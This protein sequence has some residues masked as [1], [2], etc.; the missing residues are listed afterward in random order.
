MVWDDKPKLE[1]DLSEINA[2]TK[3]ISNQGSDM[4]RQS[5]LRGMVELETAVIELGENFNYELC[6]QQDNTSVNKLYW[7]QSKPS[8]WMIQGVSSPQR[9]VQTHKLIRPQQRVALRAP[10]RTPSFHRPGGRNIQERRF[11]IRQQ[12]FLQVREWQGVTRLSDTAGQSMKA[13]LLMLVSLENET[14]A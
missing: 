11:A 4:R 2:T 3:V 13:L 7:Y 1:N 12:K 8:H 5:T 14:S 6:Q 9:P 10:F